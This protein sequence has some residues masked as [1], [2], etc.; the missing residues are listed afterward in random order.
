[1]STADSAAAP[2]KHGR[3]WVKLGLVATV[4]VGLAAGGFWYH[5]HKRYK[6]LATHEA[7]MVYRSAWLEPDVMAELIERHQI[8]SVVNLCAPG[9]MGEHR[10]AA[11]RQAVKN[12]GGRLLELS[13][14]NTVDV[15][16]P[17]IQPHMAVL[18]DPDNYP[19]LV[20]CQHGVTR[21]S[22]FLAMYDICMRGETAE[23][24]L[25]AQPKFGRDDHNVNVR[26]F[27]LEFERQHN[28]LYPEV[29]ASALDVLHH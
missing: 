24:S 20:H 23:Q 25:A 28:R 12:A 18:A 9:E 14:P 19:M 26:A 21:T 2:V 7:G 6:H 22:K 4:V 29:T 11:E 13:M 27:C 10:W 1:M 5:Q 3:S 8:R 15:N 16:D 17:G